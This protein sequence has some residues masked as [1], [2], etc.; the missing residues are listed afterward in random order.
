MNKVKLSLSYS[1][2]TL[3][4]QQLEPHIT[5]W[6]DDLNLIQHIDLLSK[7]YATLKEKTLFKYE[8]EKKYKLTIAESVSFLK[9]LTTTETS[10]AYH[11]ALKTKLTGTIHKQITDITHG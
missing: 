4:C 9:H 5:Q 1:D 8:N 6:P 3:L 7:L 11:T 2:A 10:S